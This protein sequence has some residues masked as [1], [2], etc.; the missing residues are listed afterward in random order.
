MTLTTHAAVGALVAAALYHYMP[1]D[2]GLAIGLAGALLSHPLLDAIPHWD[3]SLGAGDFDNEHPLNNDINVHSKKFII[4]LIKISFDFWLGIA[5]VCILF[6]HAP[7]AVLMTALG[8]ALL[9]IAPDPLQFVY[10]KTRSKLIEPIQRFH[11]F[12]HARLKLNARPILG[13]SCQIAILIIVS[14]ISIHIL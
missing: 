9:G 6:W 5:I 4:D 13:I 11:M 14:I 10:W 2:A 12:M 8:G 7:F 1:T 3:Y